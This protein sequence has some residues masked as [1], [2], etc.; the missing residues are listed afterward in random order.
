MNFVS[1]EIRIQTYPL[2]IIGMPMLLKAR[3]VM[4]SGRRRKIGLFQS[5]PLSCLLS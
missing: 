2:L 5:L 3:V 1:S 4:T